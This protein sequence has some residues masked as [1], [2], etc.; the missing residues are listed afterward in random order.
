MAVDVR[1]DLT[2]FHSNLKRAQAGD[3]AAV[4]AVLDSCRGYLLAMAM[5][6]LQSDLRAKVAA[7]D[8]VQETLLEGQR[9]FR[10]FTG[11]DEE[12]LL[13]WLQ[14]I[15]KNNLVDSIRHCRS[16]KRDARR[17]Q[18][19]AATDINSSGWIDHSPRP[20]QLVQRAELAD[21]VDRAI[22]LLPARHKTVILLHHREGIGFQEI[23][24]RLSVSERMARYLWAEAVS[25]LRDLLAEAE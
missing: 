5:A 6:E 23:G 4:G 16:L 22:D 20:S 24:R 19:A 21:A 14:R 18:T 1:S 8:I 2:T 10:R 15:L 11:K 9:D 3:A 7:S 13:R 12:D 25:S 17:E